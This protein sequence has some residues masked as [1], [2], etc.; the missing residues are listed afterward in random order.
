MI[1]YQSS[2]LGLSKKKIRC[3]P[4]LKIILCNSG[5]HEKS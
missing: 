4:T 3:Y 2:F 5:F 1:D